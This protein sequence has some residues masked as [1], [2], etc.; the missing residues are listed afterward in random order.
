MVN[1]IISHLPGCWEHADYGHQVH[2]VFL[3]STEARHIHSQG[4]PGQLLPFSIQ[5][6]VI[7]VSHPKSSALGGTAGGALGCLPISQEKPSQVELPQ[8]PLAAGEAKALCGTVEKQNEGAREFP[9][10]CLLGC[11]N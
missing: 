10:S 5:L 3:L 8:L 7:Y 1:N 4:E 9:E 2:S 6:D 11:T